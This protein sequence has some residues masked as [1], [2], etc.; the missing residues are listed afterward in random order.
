MNGQC[1]NL[2]FN[3]LRHPL[4]HCPL[5]LRAREGLRLSPGAC[6]N[7][8]EKLRPAH[9]THSS[10]LPPLL[11]TFRS[12]RAMFKTSKALTVWIFDQ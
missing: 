6:A 1:A 11:I 12:T 9:L 2:F 4:I 10:L 3:K 7:Q 5:M 8:G